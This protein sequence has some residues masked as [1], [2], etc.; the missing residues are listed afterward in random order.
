M[1]LSF[2]LIYI[3]KKIIIINMEILNETDKINY[4]MTKNKNGLINYNNFINNR[5]ILNEYELSL[6]LKNIMINNSGI[7]ITG[8]VMNCERHLNNI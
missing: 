6:S 2:N 8:C 1:K 4:V 3:K 7:Y 5:K